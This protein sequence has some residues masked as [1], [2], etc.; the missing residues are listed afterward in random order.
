MD[1]IRKSK[2]NRY[3]KDKIIK[4]R[5]MSIDKFKESL[6]DIV[7]I[8]TME[9]LDTHSRTILE[10]TKLIHNKDSEICSLNSKISKIKNEF[11][12]IIK[13]Q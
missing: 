3:E 1:I 13:E 5:G 7:H 9:I 8:M 4:T 11:I 10:L 12:N 2:E 6:P